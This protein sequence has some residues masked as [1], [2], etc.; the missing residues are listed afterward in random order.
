LKKGY[1]VLEIERDGKG[2]DTRYRVRPVS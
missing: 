1:T 2:R